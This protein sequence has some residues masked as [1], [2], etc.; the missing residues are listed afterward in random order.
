[1]VAA[2]ESREAVVGMAGVATAVAVAV[3]V[4][5]PAPQQLAHPGVLAV[6]MIL[7]ELVRPARE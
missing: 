5:L 3:L 4:V 1:M 7:A 2:G 6:A